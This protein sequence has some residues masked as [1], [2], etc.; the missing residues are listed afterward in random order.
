M[1]LSFFYFFKYLIVISYTDVCFINVAAEVIFLTRCCGTQQEED[2]VWLWPGVLFVQDVVMARSIEEEDAWVA[3]FG[4]DVVI[5]CS[6]LSSI[7][8]F[9]PDGYV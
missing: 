4:E 8:V 6:A 1:I 7:H 9:H 2:E 3:A 5:D